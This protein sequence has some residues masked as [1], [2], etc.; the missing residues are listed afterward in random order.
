MIDLY[1]Y[2]CEGLLKGMDDTLA[3][4]ESDAD[5]LRIREWLE[6]TTRKGFVFTDLDNCIDKDNKIIAYNFNPWSAYA[7][8]KLSLP[9]PDY[10]R[11]G[12]VNNI[13]MT[14]QEN[15]DFAILPHVDECDCLLLNSFVDNLKFDLSK[16][17]IDRVK[18]F[19][20]VYDSSDIIKYP[21]NTTI[22]TFIMWHYNEPYTAFGSKRFMI[23][24]DKL[25]GLKCNSLAIP[26]IIFTKNYSDFNTGTNSLIKKGLFDFDSQPGKELLKL[27]ND[28]TIQFKNLYVFTV[29]GVNHKF[30]KIKKEKNCFSVEN[31]GISLLKFKIKIFSN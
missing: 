15:V 7:D 9:A 13:S 18:C 27:Y 1:K 6:Y 3:T 22:D 8:C 14:I 25:K 12:S 28:N 4:G 30:Y 21:K 31:H 5:Y 23:G 2:I 11:F 17:P 29:C 10:I 16:L 26:D 24:F 19:Q 20:W